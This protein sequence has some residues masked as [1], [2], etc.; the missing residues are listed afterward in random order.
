MQKTPTITT[1]NQGYTISYATTHHHGATA[2]RKVTTI[3][4]HICSSVFGTNQ[5]SCLVS[6]GQQSVRREPWLTSWWSDL[7]RLYH[8]ARLRSKLLFLQA[9]SFDVVKVR[10]STRFATPQF[11]VPS[12]EVL[13]LE[14]G[15][16]LSCKQSATID[17]GTR[18]APNRP[19]SAVSSLRNTCD[20]L[21]EARSQVLLVSTKSSV[22]SFL[23]RAHCECAEMPMPMRA[24]ATRM[25]PMFTFL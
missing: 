25:P 7:S 24:L 15:W 23:R 1:E 13:N 14:L 22:S 6:T 4:V 21:H 5:L 18:R 19:L 11:D 10:W 8:C 2:P 3:S 12:L 9:C 16:L 17:V 20:G